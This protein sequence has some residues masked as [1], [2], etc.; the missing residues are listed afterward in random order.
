M[1]FACNFAAGLLSLLPALVFAESD[2]DRLIADTGIRKGSVHARDLPGWQ[3]ADKILV[4]DF[5]GLAGELQPHFPNINFVA[6]SS[7]ADAKQHAAGA[8]AIIGT[9]DADLLAAAPDVKWVQVFSAGVD[10][11]IPNE[12][13]ESGRVMLTNMQKMSSP[14]LAEHAITMVMSLARGLIAHGKLMKTGEWRRRDPSTAQIESVSGKTLLV[15]GLGG[16]GTEVAKR[17][18][19]VGMRVIGTRR[20]SREGPDFVEYVGLSDELFKLAAE[21]DYIVNALPLTDETRGIFD[22]AFFEAAKDGA[23]FVSIGRGA[24]TV[25]DDLIAAMKSGKI[26]GAG[27]DVTDPE[28]LPSNHPLWQMQNVIITPHIGSAGGN[29]DRHRVLLRENL[30]RFVAGD[31]LY[32]VVDPAKG[33]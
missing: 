9:C 10:R 12:G 1:K 23:Y 20:S 33:Y 31:A 3:G 28:P 32:N 18:A 6:F 26:S 27:L 30:R 15:V 8:D 14:V 5:G 21:A 24:S 25:T 13:I 11:C 16:I 29:R 2:I 4:S 19:A 17:G 22:A 7:I